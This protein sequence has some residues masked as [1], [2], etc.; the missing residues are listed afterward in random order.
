MKNLYKKLLEIQKAVNVL[1]KD[2]TG[3]GYK[4]ASGENLLKV[5]RPAMDRTG[6]LLFQE[7]LESKTEHVMWKLSKF[8]KQQTFTHVK[9]KFT[10]VDI[11]SGEKIEHL[12]EASGFNDW[13]K[14]IGSAMTYAERYYLMKTFHIPTDNLDPDQ[15]K[16]EVELKETVPP[17]NKATNKL[18]ELI[19]VA[20]INKEIWSEI[21]AKYKVDGFGKLTEKQARDEIKIIKEAK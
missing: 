3:N 16:E 13:D 11:E 5:I 7:I 12:F 14:A 4:Y 15:R 18:I 21:L 20:K 9:F 1:K 8:D 10:W 2:K 6:L 19:K 17:K